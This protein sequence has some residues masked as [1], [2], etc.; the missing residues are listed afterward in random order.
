MASNDNLALA[1]YKDR[2]GPGD[3]LY[4]LFDRSMFIHFLIQE[5]KDMAR[6]SKVS[7][8]DILADFDDHAGIL[9]DGMAGHAESFI[10]GT[11]DI[12]K[13]SS[14]SNGASMVHG[15]AA[16]KNF[17][18]L[19]YDIAMAETGELMPDRQPGVSPSAQRVWKY[20]KNKRADVES[21]PLDNKKKPITPQKSDDARVHNP[22]KEN[23]GNFL[24]SSYHLTGKKPDVESMISSFKRLEK[25]IDVKLGIPSH[26]LED[27]LWNAADEFYNIKHDTEN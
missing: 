11:I 22:G 25:Y 26:E 2:D 12:E 16:S 15:P 17:G 10:M 24:D 21:T 23:F 27:I 14:N 6:A 4:I 5:I 7:V 8:S 1:V 18:P 13:A 19:M 9:P 3:I 20:Y